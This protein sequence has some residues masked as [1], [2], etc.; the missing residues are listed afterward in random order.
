MTATGDVEVPISFGWHPYFRVPGRRDRWSL[1]AP[2]RRHLEL[3]RTGIPTGTSTRENAGTCAYRAS[4][5]TTSTHSAA[6]AA[7]T[8]PAPACTI[9]VRFASGYPY[10]QLF[11]PPGQAFAAIE[12][13]TAAT[14]AL[15]TGTCPLVPAGQTLR[16][17]F[18]VSASS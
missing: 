3:D 9:T 6:T 8:S 13:M 4:R 7:S 11:A 14:D 16:A 1:R 17:A 12:P 18:T 2:A 10:A 5:S 15:V